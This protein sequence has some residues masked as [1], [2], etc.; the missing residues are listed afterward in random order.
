MGQ[1]SFRWSVCGFCLWVLSVAAA[2]ADPAA[3]VALPDGAALQGDTAIRVRF[4]GSTDTG[5]DVVFERRAGDGW[6]TAGRMPEGAWTVCSEWRN[7]WYDQPT[8]VRVASV[9]AGE[10]GAVASGSARI[11]AGQW[12]FQ[13][14]FTLESDFV[15]IAR[16]FDYQGEGPSSKITLLTRVRLPVGPDVRMLIP[17]SIYNGN[18]GSTMP[19]PRLAPQPGQAGIY[20]EH[21]L[22]IPLANVESAAAGG[23]GGG[24]THGSIL[25]VPSR[26]AYGHKGDDQWWSLGLEFGDGFVD[27]VSLSGPVATNGQRSTIYGHRNGFD[28]YDEA[29]LDLPGP[30]RYCK[31]LYLD[32]GAERPIGQSFRAMMWKAYDVLQ[33]VQTPHVAFDQALGH[34][35]QYAKTT[36]YRSPAGAAGYCWFPWPNRL[37]QYAWCGGGESIAWAMLC[38]AERTGDEQARRQGVE[39]IDFYLRHGQ[40]RTPGLYYGDYQAEQNRWVPAS[41]HGSQ[42]GVASRQFGEIFDRL[43]D[44]VY[45]ARKMQ[46]P[47]AADWEAAVRKAGDFLL[48]APRIRG[49]FPRA[50]QEDGTVLGD[51]AQPAT[52]SAAGATCVAA[53]ARIG[54]LTGERKYVQAA[55]AAMDAYHREFLAGGPMP[56]WGSTIDAGGE[57]KEAG[58]G[59]LRAAIEV[60]QATGEQRFLEQ[61][62]DAAD[63]TLTWAYFFDVQVKKDCILHGHMNTTGWTF[64]S[65]QNQEIDVFA[66]WFAHDFYRLGLALKDD[67]YCRL[68]RVLFAACTQTI[69]RPGTM[70][71][72]GEIGIQAEHYNHT[73]CTYV[74]GHPQTWRGAAWAHGI[75]WTHAGAL[76]GGLKLAELAPAE[77]PLPPPA[78]EL[79]VPTSRCRSVLWRYT[80][81]KPADGWERPDFDDSPWAQGPGGFGEY[82]TPGGVIGTF[83]RTKEIYL[84]REFTLPAV[85][86]RPAL[87]AHYDDGAEFY[88]NGVPAA[89]TQG[90]TLEYGLLPVSGEAAAALRPGRNVLAIHCSQDFGGQYIDA[91][92]VEEKPPG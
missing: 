5:Y 28:P 15:R 37:F 44:A 14:R 21:R 58:T 49:M 50:W 51:P 33:P 9:A 7:A 13:D 84:R 52:L 76:Y 74:G 29:Y 79:P 26:I 53:L 24:R 69:S 47:Q 46:L 67:R 62:R 81:N 48:A 83:W 68:G 75:G 8:H 11:G 56:P 82:G 65:V 38:Q 3:L 25:A 32:L 30:A 90:Y 86:Q 73:N 31:T 87:L 41:F 61:A 77:F 6:V 42:P 40:T 63:W 78:A 54:Q 55:A 89:Q 91:G 85:P 88:I 72:R 59:L 35:Y 10:G 27:L 57:D 2:T 22:P 1:E 80:T 39:A 36:F 18:P 17:G 12:L 4:V 23:G 20:E 64:I 34:K 19:G 66:Y 16:T 43:C 70:L 60:Y 45:Q 71:G 92:L